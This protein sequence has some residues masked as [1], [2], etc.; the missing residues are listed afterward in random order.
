MK[1]QCHTTSIEIVFPKDRPMRDRGGFPPISSLRAHVVFNRFEK[2]R[3]R[4]RP[5][6]VFPLD[7]APR[8]KKKA[9]L[10]ATG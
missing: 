8:P 2:N 1:F 3:S 10:V 5:I 9:G 4:I 7:I 6:I